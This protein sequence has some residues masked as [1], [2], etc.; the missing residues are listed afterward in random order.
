MFLEINLTQQHAR[1][2][3]TRLVFSSAD[4]QSNIV[5]VH[6]LYKYMYSLHFS[7]WTPFNTFFCI[8]WLH[9]V[10]RQSWMRS[11]VKVCNDVK[12]WLVIGNS[13]SKFAVK[14]VDEKQYHSNCH[15][16][17]PFYL[18]IFLSCLHDTW[19]NMADHPDKYCICMYS[20]WGK[21]VCLK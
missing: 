11:L 16:Q 19:K 20:M 8:T 14:K 4:L 1:T 2:V 6:L 9:T 18:T 7:L 21:K 5:E 17:C 10:W 13:W 15:N 12:W 3:K